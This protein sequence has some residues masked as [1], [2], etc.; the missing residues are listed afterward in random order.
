MNSMLEKRT[1]SHHKSLRN[2]NSGGND[3]PNMKQVASEV[4]A[5]DSGITQTKQ[6]MYDKVYS[7]RRFLISSSQVVFAMLLQNSNLHVMLK[8]S[9]IILKQRL[10]I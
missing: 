9:G 7:N 5:A 10:A 8:I 2:S 4:V 3:L 6:D 1:L